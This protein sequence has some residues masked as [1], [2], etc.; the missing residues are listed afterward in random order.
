MSTGIASNAFKYQLAI[1]AP[2]LG[3][4]TIKVFLMRSGF[5]F[6]QDDHALKQNII[7]SSSSATLTCTQGNQRITRDSG[8]FIDEGFVI[9]NQITTDLSSN[10]GPFIV[11]EVQE[12][13]LG[14]ESGL[15]NE[16]PTASKIVSS[17]DELEVKNG[18]TSD[19]ELSGR[20][21]SEDDEN[22]R[23]EMTC[24]DISWTA[25]D[26]DIGPTPGAILCDDT[27]EGK[28]VIGFIDFEEEQTASMGTDFEILHLRIRIS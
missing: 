20:L 19:T 9:G 24:D 22:N 26:G 1:G 5:V 3:A 27:V 17:N 13:Y 21:I 14:V 18:Y 12:L 8:S 7:T 15:V 4:D 2:N 25:T 11:T 16:G 10:G 23:A 28:P 6:N